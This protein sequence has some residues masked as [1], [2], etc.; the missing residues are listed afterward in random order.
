MYTLSRYDFNLQI[1]CLMSTYFT[2]LFLQLFFE[3]LLKTYI[4]EIKIWLHAKNKPTHDPE[5]I[6]SQ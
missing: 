6:Y 1:I 4:N 3:Y 5:Y 2:A